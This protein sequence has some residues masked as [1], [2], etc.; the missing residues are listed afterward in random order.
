MGASSKQT[1]VNLNPPS[2][3][4]ESGGPLGGALGVSLAVPFFSYWLA[5]VCDALPMPL[6]A[7]LD[8][9]A[10]GV[11]AMQSAA[12]W[13]SL[14]SWEATAVYCAWYAWAVMCWFVLPGEEVQG[15][16][17]RDGKRLSYTMNGFATLVF[18]LAALAGWTYLTGLDLLLYIPHHWAQ[19]I[20]AALAMAFFQAWFVYLQSFTGNQLLALGGNTQNGFF[21]VRFP[22]F[23]DIKVFNELRPGLVLWVII[24]LA[25][26]ASHI[27][28]T[29]AFHVWYVFDSLWD[30]AAMLTTMDITTDGFGFML[31]VG[32]LVWLPFT[33]SYTAYWLARHPVDL[34]LLGCA[35]V[36][37]VQLVGYWIF[38]ASN[39]EKNEFRLGR[40]PKNLQSLQTQRG[41]RL[42]TSGWWGLS[43]HPNYF[44]DW[45]MAWAWCLPCGFS[46][47]LPYFYVV[48]FAVLPVHRQRRDDEAC[49]KKYGKDW[50]TYKR[51]VPWR[52]I[53][54][55]Y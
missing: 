46:S 29:S 23:F 54:Y 14:W 4:Y 40:N 26:I 41:T 39:S 55:I 9:H 7:F 32:D 19:L 27:V 45:I 53:P 12:W 15:V 51:V 20:G 3:H 22:L 13:S 6:S 48:Y 43:R 28:L 49:E 18:T 38:R 36:I 5:F 30:E 10:S 31:A 16:E 35:A 33:Y 50:E 2:T 34:G 44:G 52:I 1:T 21:N 17:L 42:L 37:A 47:P 8:W 11:A 24:D 25:M